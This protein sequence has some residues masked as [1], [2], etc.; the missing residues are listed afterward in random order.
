MPVFREPLEQV[1]DAAVQPRPLNQHR[2]ERR[3]LLGRGQVAVQQQI[4]HSLGVE[5]GELLDGITDVRDPLI[6]ID[7][8]GSA[9][10][11]GKPPQP[12]VEVGLG[13][14]EENI[15]CHRR[16]LWHGRREKGPGQQRYM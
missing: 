4:D 13:D 3:E 14:L 16:V 5:V 1:D 9:S 2:L 7:A 12:R 8:A 6:G 10:A 15:V 11:N